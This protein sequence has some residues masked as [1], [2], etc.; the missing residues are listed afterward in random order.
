MT[1]TPYMLFCQYL[2]P[3]GKLKALIIRLRSLSWVILEV[4]DASLSTP[5]YSNP[6]PVISVLT[7]ITV[8]LYSMSIAFNLVKG[9]NTL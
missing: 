1:V 5:A 6:T 4:V 9:V 2:M 8:M 3:V 7:L